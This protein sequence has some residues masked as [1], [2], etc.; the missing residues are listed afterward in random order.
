MTAKVRE[1]ERQQ[2]VKVYLNGG[3][4]NRFTFKNGTVSADVMLKSGRNTLRVTARN[5]AGQAEDQ[6]TVNYRQPT[7]PPKVTIT[8]PKPSRF[9][10]KATRADQTVKASITN[11]DKKD[12]VTFLFNGKSSRNFNYDKGQFSA[13]VKLKKGKNTI[14]I[15]GKNSAGEDEAQVTV[16]YIPTI[17]VAKPT[18]KISSPTGKL[19]KNQAILSA[20]VTNVASKNDIQVLLDGRKVSNFDFNGKLRQVTGTYTVKPGKHSITVIVKNKAGEARDKTSFS[21]QRSKP[22]AVQPTINSFTNSA[23]VINPMRPNTAQTTVRATLTG[24][25]KKK[26]IQMTVN[27]KSFNNFTFSATTGQLVAP[28]TLAKGKNSILLKATTA[29]G[30]VK[31]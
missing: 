20:Q 30:T 28:I 27:G 14:K 8:T 24:V 1:V 16:T 21:Y 25:S 11:V 31:K 13:Q 7:P 9:G 15:K 3:S 18:V 4:L 29:G 10:T 6:V 23:P 19:K 17:P 26:E 22:T 5:Q 12:N 2:D